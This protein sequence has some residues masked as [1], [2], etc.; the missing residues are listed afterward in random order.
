[1]KKIDSWLAPNNAKIP[2]F[3]ICGAMKSGT[4]TLHAI[5][6]KHPDIY[7]PEKEIHFF[8]MDNIIQH[9]DFN[10]FEK[11]CWSCHSVE[12]SPKKYWQWY[13]SNFT[14][15]NDNQIIGEDSTTYLASELAAKRI[16]MQNK[17]IKTVIM[18]RLPT[19][20][21][22]SQ[23][24]HML[25]SGRATY[26]F[27]DT[28]KFAPSSIL[29]R[30]LYF[31]QIERFLKYVPKEQVKIVIFEEFLVDKVKC[32]E[33]VCKFLGVDFELLP[34]RAIDLHE[35]AAKYPKYPHLQFLKNRMFPS[36][37]NSSYVDIFES[38]TKVTLSEKLSMSKIIDKAHRLINPLSVN[39]TARMIPETRKFLDD[40]FYK[41]LDGINELLEKD[42]L[43][44]WFNSFE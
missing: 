15:A 34:M 12:K 4:S 18:L 28:L 23:Y 24:W 42:V 5:L 7:I 21:E 8:D 38:N 19:L 40:Y 11:G 32:V 39:K 27:E 35:N 2:D 26:S 9:P 33:D 16:G 14:S 20:R 6:A 37:G 41:E 13:L 29:N 43:S 10:F 30:S 17:A 25:R 36:A 31:Q 44:V 3:I 22:Y 1:M